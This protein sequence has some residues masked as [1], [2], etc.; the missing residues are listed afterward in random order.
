MGPTTQTAR[1]VMHHKYSSQQFL[2]PLKTNELVY[3]T[4]TL[5]IFEY[6][7]KKNNSAIRPRKKMLENKMQAQCREV[8]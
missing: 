7:I 3:A 5:E 6:K 2:L 1:M 8:N 4:A